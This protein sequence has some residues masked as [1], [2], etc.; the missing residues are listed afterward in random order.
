[1]FEL[2]ELRIPIV[3]APMAGGPS[4]PSL[5]RA[6]GEVGGLGFLA[7]GYLAPEALAE[8]IDAVRTATTAPF[9]VN[10][11]VPQPCPA[12]SVV[13][14]YRHEL[15][16]E[17]ERYGVTLPEA[18]PADDDH[19]DS[20]I[21]MLIERP[22]PVVSITFGVPAPDVVSELHRAGT[23]VL[24]T[25]T[26]PAEA[27][28]AAAAGVDGLCVQGPGAGAHRG[29][30]DVAAEPGRTP[31]GALL[32]EISHPAD[33]PLIAAGGLATGSSVAAA[34]R[35]GARA[36][37]V[38]TAYLR[39]PESGA[40][41]AYKAAL[42]DPRFGPAIVTRAFSGRPARGLRNRFTDAHHA[43]APA[44]YP[45]VNQLTQPLRAAAA[46][47]GDPDGLSLWA[48]S[49]YRHATD[50]PAGQLTVRLWETAQAELAG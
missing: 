25:V 39:T 19:W 15:A 14:A 17:A 32:T 42:V 45:L 13:A 12:A 41:P 3:Q 43:T 4:T 38:G 22:V 20:K 16:A 6:V 44:A 35:A 48:G 36:V 40:K 2:G 49:G 27:R 18:D 11:F 9:G 30:F 37:Q 29:T 46:A 28:I 26:S 23:Y 21:K 31:L 1:V 24:G 7:A 50:E 10:V 47:R 8:Q 33:L 5:V 34:L